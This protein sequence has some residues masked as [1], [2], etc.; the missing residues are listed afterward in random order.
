[1]S[2]VA[3][4]RMIVLYILAHSLASKPNHKR[5]SANSRPAPAPPAFSWQTPGLEWGC[6]GPP[7]AG[8][9][10]SC[11]QPGSS[12]PGAGMNLSC[13]QPGSSTQGA[14]VLIWTWERE[15]SQAW[16]LCWICAT[17]S[18]RWESDYHSH[19]EISLHKDWQKTI[20]SDT[21]SL[22]LHTTGTGASRRHQW[23]QRQ[24]CSF[25]WRFASMHTACH[26]ACAD[27]LFVSAMKGILSVD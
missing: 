23:G 26:T 4:Y 11:T 7:G 12:T 18:T 13:T 19:S 1:M 5:L 10:L 9:N 8:M 14:A 22:D 2:R 15:T 21:S 20:Q 27:R 25:A 17:C 24:L 6:E 3:E 16:T